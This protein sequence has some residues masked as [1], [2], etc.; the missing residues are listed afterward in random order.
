MSFGAGG[1]AGGLISGYAWDAIGAALTYSL[2]SGFALAGLAL[3]WLTFR[4]PSSAD[5]AER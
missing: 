5:G 1:M 4:E 3:V 2:S